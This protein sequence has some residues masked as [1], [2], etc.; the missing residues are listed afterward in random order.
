MSGWFVENW[1]LLLRLVLFIPVLGYVVWTDVR[2]CVI[3]DIAIL[4][5]LVGAV[6]LAIVECLL[7][8]SWLPLGHMA[9]SFAVGGLPFALVILVTRG[10]MGAGDMKL[11]ALIGALFMWQ[12]AILTMVF[13]I[14]LAGMFAVV[15]LV[16][17]K[18]SRTTRIPLAPFLA[19]GWGIVMIFHEP[20]AGLLWIYYGI[21]L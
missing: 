15:L 12:T 19:V 5:G 7:A 1:A 4:I 9:L 8:S 10:G 18:V 16:W 20:I 2:K 11:M 21:V 17:K 14:V 13:G 3:P 6:A